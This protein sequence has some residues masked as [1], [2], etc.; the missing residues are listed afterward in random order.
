MILKT[1]MRQLCEDKN[2]PLDEVDQLK[3]STISAQNSIVDLQ[4]ELLTCK[5]QQ[6]NAVQSSVK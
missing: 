1:A 2:G 6:L 5:D 4:K 3:S